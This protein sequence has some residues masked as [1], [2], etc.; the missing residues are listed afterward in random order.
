MMKPIM[1]QGSRGWKP[2]AT[3]KAQI[4]IVRV[5]SMTDLWAD[6]AY[7]VTAMPN[8]LKNA[9]EKVDRIV[10]KI[11]HPLFFIC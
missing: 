1:D 3:L 5:V 6:E 2:N 4:K 10:S 8:V 11:S 7:L 9:I